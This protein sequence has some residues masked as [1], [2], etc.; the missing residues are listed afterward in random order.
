MQESMSSVLQKRFMRQ[1]LISS[2][3][4]ISMKKSNVIVGIETTSIWPLNEERY[5]KSRFGIPLFEKYQK[6]VESEKPKSDWA[7]YTNTAKEPS[8]VDFKNLSESDISLDKS[9]IMKNQSSSHQSSTSHQ[10]EDNTYSQ[11]VLN[12]L[13]PYLLDGPPGFKRVPAGWKLEPNQNQSNE[14]G[15]NTSQPNSVRNT[16]FE[17][18]FLDKIKPFKK[19]PQKK[20]RKINLSAA[21]ISDPKLLQQLEVK[22]SEKQKGGNLRKKKGATCTEK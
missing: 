8:T 20:R 17:E 1:N 11:D 14:N 3:W 13:G 16:S 5:D 7:S 6:C 18:P 2:I 12:V 22:E 21:V 4:H 9:A 19:S 15:M 10:S